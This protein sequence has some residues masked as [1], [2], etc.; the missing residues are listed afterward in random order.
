MTL[1]N[2]ARE[3][4]SGGIFFMAYE[5]IATWNWLLS[6][7]HEINPGMMTIFS[8]QDSAG[9]PAIKQFCEGTGR[10]Q[11][12]C[13]FHKTNNLMKQVQ[14]IAGAEMAEQVR[15]LWDELV[16]T[17]DEDRADQIPGEILEMVPTLESYWVRE[18]EPL[19]PLITKLSVFETRTLDAG[20][21]LLYSTT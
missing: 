20:W 3:I 19:L 8:D 17:S 1:I 15:R 12:L 14:R 6:V 13:K 4:V 9:F 10:R 21:C 7:L 18:I 5:T 11:R 2:Y 16:Y